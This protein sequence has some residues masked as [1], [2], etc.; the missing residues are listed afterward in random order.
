MCQSEIPKQLLLSEQVRNFWEEDQLPWGV[1]LDKFIVCYQVI[2]Y[3]NFGELGKTG[4]GECHIRQASKYLKFRNI[5]E[6][7]LNAIVPPPRSQKM[8]TLVG[9]KLYSSW[10]GR[11]IRMKWVIES[12]LASMSLEGSLTSRF[13]LIR[14]WPSK[15]SNDCTL[16]TKESDFPY[17]AL[18]TIIICNWNGWRNAFNSPA[19]NI[20]PRLTPPEIPQ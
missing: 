20:S 3:L 8:C 19:Y 7:L 5:L 12:F 6:F 15:Y 2:V 4:T 17:I 9:D 10:I 13:R 18:D 1:S 11:R 14:L 16:G